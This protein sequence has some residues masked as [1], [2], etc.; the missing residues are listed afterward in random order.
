MIKLWYPEYSN[1]SK[2]CEIGAD[3]IIHSHVWIGD[4]V[5][6]GRRCRI[7]AFAFLPPGVVLEDD[8]FIGPHVCFT[9]DRI[10]PSQ[11]RDVTL[12]KRGARI[13]ANASIL[14]GVVIGEYSLVAM[15]SVV[16]C[17]IPEKQ[18]WAGN[19]ARFKKHV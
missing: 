19:P 17:D 5:K 8:V 13:G 4:G 14:A 12:V 16:L 3:S 15:G 10:P 2:E 1:I 18:M 9:N 11:I 6:I 7:E